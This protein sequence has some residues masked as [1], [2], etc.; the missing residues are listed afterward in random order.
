MK[1]GD[2]LG[3][4]KGISFC[5]GQ[6]WFPASVSGRSK[7]PI[8]LALRCLVLSLGL[9]GHLN[10]TYMATHTAHLHV[11][12]NK[13]IDILNDKS[14]TSLSASHSSATYCVRDTMKVISSLPFKCPSINK[15]SPQSQRIPKR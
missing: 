1:T 12:E 15:H 4:S 9:H 2:W 13:V 10:S 7:S 8:T 11:I 6:V 5:R 3:D 14:Q